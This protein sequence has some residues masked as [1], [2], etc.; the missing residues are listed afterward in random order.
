MQELK[1]N[2]SG[3]T[4]LIISNEEMNDIMKIVQALEDSNILLKEVTKS[5]KNETKEQKGGLLSMLLGILGA[6]FLGNLLTGE[7]NV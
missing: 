2:C 3:T 4:A 5:I 1:K 7:G 6:N